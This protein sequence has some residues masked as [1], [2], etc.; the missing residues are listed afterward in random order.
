MGGQSTTRADRLCA[1]TARH[2][3]G[4]VTRR[5]AHAAGL[6]DSA[7]HRRVRTMD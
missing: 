6:D 2:Q 7:I 5:Q 3:F 4:L 1:N